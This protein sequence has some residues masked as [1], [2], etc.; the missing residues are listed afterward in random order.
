MCRRTS[1]SCDQ[2]RPDVTE[3]IV[4]VGLLITVR[5]VGSVERVAGGE[6]VEHLAV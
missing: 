1:E 4:I 2:G 3:L 6:V 5:H